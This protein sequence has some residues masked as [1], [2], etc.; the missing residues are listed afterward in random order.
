MITKHCLICCSGKTTCSCIDT[1]E[2]GPSSWGENVSQLLKHMNLLS[3]N[4][5]FDMECSDVCKSQYLMIR[6]VY[7]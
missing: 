7:C 6:K 2:W 5:N 1:A 4:V 3:H